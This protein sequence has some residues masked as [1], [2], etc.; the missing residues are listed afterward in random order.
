VLV[1]EIS[2]THQIV[3]RFRARF[4]E[5]IAVLH[6]GLG[7]GERTDQW[8]SLSAERGAPD[9]VIGARSASFA[10]LRKLGLIVVDEEHDSAYQSEDVFRYHAREVAELRGREES[11][12]VELGSAWPRAPARA[13]SAP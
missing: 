5:R 6:S 3:D 4:G 1:P 13:H 12:P 10:P 7:A 2:L 8:R 11:C 9:I